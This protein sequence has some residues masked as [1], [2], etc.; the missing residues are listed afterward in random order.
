VEGAL[1]ALVSIVY[2]DQNYASRIAKF[3]LG[4]PHNEVFGVFW[5]ELLA[6][7]RA[8]LWIAPPSPF[9]ALELHGGYLLPTFRQLFAQV[10]GGY[11][12]RP[13]QEVVRRQAARGG[14]VREDFLTRDGSW[15]RPADL[16]PLWDLLDL[17]LSGSFHRRAMIAAEA[18]ARRL[19]L[20]PAGAGLPFV[21]VLAR[22][23]AFRSQETA[24]RERLADLVDLVM[25]ATVRPYAQAL[26]TD[27]FLREALA[28]TGHG[29]AVFSGRAAEV[30]AFADW[31][32][33][34]RDEAHGQSLP[35]SQEPP[36]G[37]ADR[38]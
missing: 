27:R 17:E 10:S 13:W 38:L 7:V 25:A 32:R 14:L 15:D 31:L 19:G 1:G 20:G 33:M 23:L 36:P 30:R 4:L 28:R 16:A 22:L 11:W 5:R 2:L 37:D 3:L 26:G 35:R 24:R 9:H 6:G 21:R 34:R 12:V 18:I 29:R 8:G